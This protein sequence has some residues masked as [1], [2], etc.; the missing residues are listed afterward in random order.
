MPEANSAFCASKISWNLF[1]G[2][3][4]IRLQSARFDRVDG[5][6]VPVTVQAR[7]FAVRVVADDVRMGDTINLAFLYDARDVGRHR[8]A[9]QGLHRDGVVFAFDQ[10]DDL[11]PEVRYGLRKAT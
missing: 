3:P 4:Q 11:D 8:R 2:A 9:K 5:G 1:I 10:F 6:V 7:Y